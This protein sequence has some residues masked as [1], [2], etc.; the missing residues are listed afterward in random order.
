MYADIKKQWVDALRSDKY[1]SSYWNWEIKQDDG[2]T[3]CGC[4]RAV[5]ADIY[6]TATGDKLNGYNIHESQ[7]FIDWSGV[8]QHRPQKTLQAVESQY[9]QYDTMEKVRLGGKAFLLAADWIDT[10]V[11]AKPPRQETDLS[12]APLAGVLL[13]EAQPCEQLS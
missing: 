1:K 2:G 7:K 13:Q 11:E 4:V 3:K 9:A 10:N 6:N 8:D 5:L 12:D